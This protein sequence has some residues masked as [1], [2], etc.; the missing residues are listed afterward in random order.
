MGFLVTVYLF[1]TGLGVVGADSDAVRPGFLILATRAVAVGWVASCI[2]MLRSGDSAGKF[3]SWALICISLTCIAVRIL[4]TGGKE[5]LFE[6]VLQLL[7]VFHYLKNRLAIWQV[8]IVLVPVLLLGFGALNFY[9][10]VIIGE[11]GAPKS[12][13]D[14]LVRTSAAFD[15]LRS[16]KTG[17]RASAVD[18]MLSR[19]A[20]VDALALVV[21]FT[22][23]PQPYGWGASFVKAIIS[24]AVPRVLWPD[25]P[26]YD[27]SREF[28][29]GYMG[30]SY[31]YEG[32]SSM[33]TTADLYRNFGYFG[34]AA[35]MMLFGPL[36]QDAI[37]DPQTDFVIS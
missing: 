13:Q 6:P 17:G 8:A 36:S 20:G 16:G 33:H 21:K 28:E 24:A 15:D 10:F 11:Q 30:M 25:K 32:H 19:Q 37:D 34:V 12:F 31:E 22:P 7:I 2:Y 5:A 29:Q 14:V 27:S 35:G 23:H 18:Q 4:I 3:L 26:I 1:R 9:R